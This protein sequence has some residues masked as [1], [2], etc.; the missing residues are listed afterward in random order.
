VAE[1]FGVLR[2]DGVAE[3]ALFLID[4]KGIIRYIDVHNI[5]QRPPLETLVQE[6]EKVN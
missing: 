3:R 2:S 6:L 1:K 5:N 4:K